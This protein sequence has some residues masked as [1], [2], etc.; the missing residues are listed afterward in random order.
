MA[1]FKVKKAKCKIAA[2]NSKIPSLRNI[3]KL[4]IYLKFCFVVLNLSF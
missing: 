2:Q 4:A 3:S 1:Q